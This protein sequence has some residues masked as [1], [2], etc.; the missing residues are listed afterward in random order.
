MN[1]RRRSGVSRA[2]LA[3][4]GFV[5]LRRPGHRSAEWD[6]FNRFS[7]AVEASSLLGCADFAKAFA[8]TGGAVAR[9]G[10][11]VVDAEDIR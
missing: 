1:A 8:R 3:A 2:W 4:E 9:A 7:R 11:R 5:D 10:A 6:S